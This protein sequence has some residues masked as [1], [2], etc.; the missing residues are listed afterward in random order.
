MADGRRPCPPRAQ[1][2]LAVTGVA[3]PYR[4]HRGRSGTVWFVCV[5]G[6]THSE[7]QHFAPGT[8]AAVRT[9]H[10]GTPRSGC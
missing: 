5:G 9:G 10:C 6:E 3:G 2:S 7:M 4:R 8:G 1:V